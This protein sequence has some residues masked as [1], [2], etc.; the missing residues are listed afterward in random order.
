VRQRRPPQAKATEG[1]P[2]RSDPT[3]GCYILNWSTSGLAPGYYLLHIDL[4]DGV[5][6]TIKVGLR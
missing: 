5:E 4:G 6:R 2:F 3:S 1:N